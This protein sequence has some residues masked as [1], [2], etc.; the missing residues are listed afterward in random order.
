MGTIQ[1]KD[2]ELVADFAK[3]NSYRIQ[4]DTCTLA[5]SYVPNLYVMLAPCSEFLEENGHHVYVSM[6]A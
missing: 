5:G 2:Y 6:E 1:A 3:K 4:I